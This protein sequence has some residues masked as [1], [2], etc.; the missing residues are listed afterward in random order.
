AI[1]FQLTALMG[2]NNL[3][4]R[5]RLASTL[6]GLALVCNN[7]SQ[8]DP[9]GWLM[10]CAHDLSNAQVLRVDLGDESYARSVS[11][12][13]GDLM[14][15]GYVDQPG[16]GERLIARTNNSLDMSSCFPAEPF[17]VQGFP[18]QTLSFTPPAGTPATTTWIAVTPTVT[19]ATFNS[20][21]LCGVQ[22]VNDAHAGPHVMLIPNPAQG[23]VRLDGLNDGPVNL[24]LCDALGRTVRQLRLVNGRAPISMQGLAPGTYQVQVEQNGL[25]RSLVLMLQ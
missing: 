14:V 24:R 5:P 25:V 3:F 7:G 15:T 22:S 1:V 19:D 9:A 20:D 23:E 11:A 2:M 17:T 8:N 16:V 21:F 4:D 6:D 13:N 18:M 12:W 10:T